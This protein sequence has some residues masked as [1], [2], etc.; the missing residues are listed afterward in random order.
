MGWMR[1]G[2]QSIEEAAGARRAAADLLDAGG[3]LALGWLFVR[4]VL[5]AARAGDDVSAA[6]LDQRA[7]WRAPR[8][9][10]GPV[11]QLLFAQVGSPGQ[12]V[13]GLRR[14]DPRTGARQA[15]WRTLALVGAR[16]GVSLAAHRLRPAPDDPERERARAVLTEEMQRAREEH[17]DDRQAQAAAMEAVAERHAHE[18]MGPDW[19]RIIVPPLVGALLVTAVRRWVAPTVLVRRR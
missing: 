13:F 11:S 15:V 7:R 3:Q 4:P 9:L 16:I 10:M 14:V 8:E 1:P 5:A 6:A 18:D 17:P 2:E 19:L 12:L